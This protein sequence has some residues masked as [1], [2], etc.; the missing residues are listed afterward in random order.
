MSKAVKSDGKVNR[1]IWD[2]SQTMAGRNREE[3]ELVLS[4]HDLLKQCEY[5]TLC[6]VQAAF[7]FTFKEPHWPIHEHIEIKAKQ[8]SKWREY[9]RRRKMS[10][11]SGGDG[12]YLSDPLAEL[13]D[14][15]RGSG[16]DSGIGTDSSSQ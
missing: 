10:D 11:V 7:I 2:L 1:L 4:N 14:R 13:R 15:C 12:E 8:S 9:E 16:T 5:G 3:V 6:S